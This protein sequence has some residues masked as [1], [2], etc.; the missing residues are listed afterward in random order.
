MLGVWAPAPDNVWTV[1]IDFDASE[2]LGG[3][4][5]VRHWTG[6]EWDDS[7]VP[8]TDTL[9]KVWGSSA[10]D[11]WLVG[12]TQGQGLVYGCTSGGTTTDPSR[13]KPTWTVRHLSKG[14][15]PF[16]VKKLSELKLMTITSAIG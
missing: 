7:D 9:W 5:Y 13:A 8:G 14:K 2:A 4:G 11:V 16:N 6:T 15:S 3:S 1:G 12:T 10:S